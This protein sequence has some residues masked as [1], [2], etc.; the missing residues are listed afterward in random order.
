MV[1]PELALMGYLP[2]DLLMSEGFVRRASRKLEAMAAEL[3]GAPPLLVGVAT[4]NPAPM[5]RPLFNSAVLLRDGGV[6]PA[7]HKTLLPTYDVFDEDRYFEPA[8]Q[9]QILDLGGWRL[10][11]SICEDVWNDRD[12]WERRRYH[13]DPVE[14]L[15]QSGAR[16]MI[17]LSA[18]PFTVGKQLL[19]E[20]MLGHMAQKHALPLVI[21]NQTG[22]NDDLIFDGHSAAFDACGRMFARARGFRDDVLVVNLADSTGTVAPEDFEPEAEIWAALVLGVRDYARKT[23]FR[24]VL[25]GLSGGID[26]ALTAA[27]AADAVGPENV[28]GVLM[29]SSYSSAG[30]VDDSV[31][32]AG[33]LGIRTVTLPIAGI[34]RTYDAVLADTFR[35]RQPDVTEENIQSRIRGTLLMALSNKF[36]SLLLTTGN[37]SEMAVGYCTLYGDM[38]GG[39]AVIADLPKMMVYRVSRWRNRRKADIPEAILTKA[40]SAELRPG[41]TDQDSLPPYELLD[42]ILE[43][44]VEHSKSAEEIIAQGFDAATVRR[45]VKLVRNAEFKRKQAAPVLKVTSR[46]F[47]T[48]WRMPIARGE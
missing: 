43:L 3:R 24:Q 32:L 30:S 40:P 31:E 48:G 47:G 26:S 15:A 16:A 18:S 46:A 7:F 23:H 45:V 37:K 4:L 44:H 6:G 9:P 17:N 27:I 13:Q 10:G 14:V 12:F 20:N 42:Q 36:G 2:R 29:P 5:G 8:A 1:T 25:L 11:I 33:N 38:N 22:G 39:L 35:G 21:V 19:R 41:Q 34:M 28:L